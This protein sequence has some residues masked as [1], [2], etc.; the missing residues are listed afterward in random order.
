MTPPARSLAE[1]FIAAE[2]Y[3]HA[4][5]S[6]HAL[7]PLHVVRSTQRVAIKIPAGRCHAVAREHERT[8][9]GLDVGGLVRFEDR[10]WGTGVALEWCP[11][12]RA[13]VPFEARP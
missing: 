11:D 7:A 13:V 3:V 5:V 6:R 4:V 8:A 12:C 9:C 10:P 1:H 2:R